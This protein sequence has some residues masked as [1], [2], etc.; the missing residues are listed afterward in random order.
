MASGRGPH[1]EKITVYLSAEE[2]LVLEETKV[3]LL[4]DGVKVDRSSI[5]RAAVEIGLKNDKA[6]SRQ[7]KKE[8]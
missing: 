2:L 6:I 8:D 1:A 4:R 5:V 3:A 7:L